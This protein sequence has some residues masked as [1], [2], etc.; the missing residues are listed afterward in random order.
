MA[1]LPVRRSSSSKPDRCL[2]SIERKSEVSFL[3]G[4][5]DHITGVLIARTSR[6]KFA[7]VVIGGKFPSM[8]KREAFLTTPSKVPPW[9]DCCQSGFECQVR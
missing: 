9:A 1:S 4:M 8:R 3:W 7:K 2:F 5:M 6:V